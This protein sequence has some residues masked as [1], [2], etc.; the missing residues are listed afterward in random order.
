MHSVE[1]VLL[2]ALSAAMAIGLVIESYRYSK[3]TKR[4][5]YLTVAFGFSVLFVLSAV[6]AALF[7]M[8]KATMA[9]VVYAV[10]DWWLITTFGAVIW[11]RLTHH[12]CSPL[13]YLSMLSV[14]ILPLSFVFSALGGSNSSMV[15]IATVSSFFYLAIA[16]VIFVK[17]QIFD[18]AIDVFSL[19]FLGLALSSMFL[20]LYGI[21]NDPAF[22]ISHKLSEIISYMLLAY[23]EWYGISFTKTM[24]ERTFYAKKITTL[25]GTL[26]SLSKET[27]DLFKGADR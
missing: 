16:V 15:V 20:S 13:A 9:G 6:S 22:L 8:G 24:Q 1:H 2:E 3:I 19:S 18:G 7:Y 4:K 10:G 26:E 23:G 5:D 12:K 21:K 17:R 27:Q 11:C 14:L 25:S